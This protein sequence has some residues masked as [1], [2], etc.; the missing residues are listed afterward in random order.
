MRFP[1]KHRNY[2][3]L[4]LPATL[5]DYQRQMG[6]GR[7]SSLLMACCLWTAR[8]FPEAQLRVQ[9]T[10]PGETPDFVPNHKMELLVEEPNP[11]Y[12]GVSML[13]AGIVDLIAD[14]NW[15]TV[16][17]RNLLG[18][19]VELWYVPSWMIEPAWDESSSTSYISHYSYKPRQGESAYKLPPEDVIHVR[20]GLD[21]QNTRKGLAPV[22]ALLREM[23]TDEEAAN[24]TASLLRNLGVPGVILSPSDSE[25]EASPEDLEEVKKTFMAKFGGDKRGEP[26]ALRTKTDVKV[27]SFSPQQ[28]DLRG[29]R[30][31]P[32]ERVTAVIG[33]PA[34]VVGFGAGLDRS[35][36]ANFKEAREA[37]FE[38]MLAPLQRLVAAEFT[39]SLL[40]DFTANREERAVFDLSQVRILQE[41]EN[42]RWERYGTAYE[43]GGLTRAEYRAAVGLHFDD[44]D[45]V[46]VVRRSTLLLPQGQDQSA[47]TI[48]LARKPKPASAP[49]NGNGSGKTADLHDTKE[50]VL[51]GH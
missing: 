11:Y 4:F 50:L 18:E 5:Y 13:M 31:I 17:V 14:G 15:Y 22:K 40:R 6:D 46:Y 33:V 45:E 1:G 30:R 23:Y 10:R 26:L 34:I 20:Y 47:T 27:L 35:T 24:F 51:H 32:E 37:A 9:V 19:P 41:D 25:A 38:S 43:K 8:T 16:K 39:R 49:T 2:A 7:T 28:M 12:T 3:S 44:T 48:E 42:H 21:P 36:F 29:L